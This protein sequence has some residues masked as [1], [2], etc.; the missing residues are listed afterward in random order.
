MAHTKKELAEMDADHKYWDEFCDALGWKLIGFT[1]RYNAGIDTGRMA[2]F[3]PTFS[4]TGAERDTIMAVIE[5][6]KIK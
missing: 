2:V 5:K 6:G 4:I 3:L 1:G